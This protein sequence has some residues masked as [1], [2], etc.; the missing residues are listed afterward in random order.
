M[1]RALLNCSNRI[2]RR[3]FTIRGYSSTVTLSELNA[4]SGFNEQ[5]FNNRPIEELFPVIASLIEAREHSRVDQVVHFCR[6]K[7]PQDWRR[8]LNSPSIP[9]M[10]FKS[11]LD[12]I[13]TAE[14]DNQFAILRKDLNINLTRSKNS[15]LPAI[16]PDVMSYALMFKYILLASEQRDFSTESIKADLKYLEIEA[17]LY[18]ISLLEILNC[19]R[20]AELIDESQQKKLE[21][22]LEFEA[23]LSGIDTLNFT[24]DTLDQS[25][26]TRTIDLPEVRTISSK[27]EGIN[28]IKDSL[29]QLFE[30]DPSAL[31]NPNIMYNLQLKLEQ[32]CYTAMIA[33]LRKE[34]EALAQVTGT[35]NLGN[36]KG[37]LVKWLDTLKL[38]L[39]NEFNGRSNISTTS[40][41]NSKDS[42]YYLALLSALDPEKISIIVIQELMKISLY[43]PYFLAGG[44]DSS[45]PVPI[46]GARL[47]TLATNIG[48]ALQREVFAVQISRKP[49]LNRS[50]LKPLQLAQMFDRKRTLDKSMR[51]VYAQL[52]GD[53][54][55]QREGWIPAWTN[56][57]KA[58]IGTFLLA[59]V[60]QTLLHKCEDGK[61][62]PVFKHCVIYSGNSRKLGV[63]RM[64]DEVF[65]KLKADKQIAFVEAWAMPMLVPPKPWLTITS[66]GYLTHKSKCNNGNLYFIYFKHNLFIYSSFFTC[67]Y[68]R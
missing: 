13:G 27:S 10:I 31:Q 32:D 11:A 47:V 5:N 8:A 58:E 55:A 15:S 33:K 18:D 57:L 41:S 56:G 63:I 36:I 49:F 16:K 44:D 25:H 22:L 4:F 46:K 29:K 3:Q 40:A 19:I 42:G 30:L 2:L 26:Q 9:N 37:E 62:E 23:Q 68:L 53:L 65:E 21:S 59:L 48:S 34:S 52:E 14:L 24:S 45:T 61:I 12:T 67:R 54:E 28:F 66:G 51:R 43:E 35:G 60:E 50:Q 6:T 38:A 1:K 39:E 64:I 20:Q 7:R 17:S